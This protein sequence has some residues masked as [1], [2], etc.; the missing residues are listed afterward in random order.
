MYAHVNSSF[1]VRLNS[2]GHWH[3]IIR[4]PMWKLAFRRRIVGVGSSGARWLLDPLLLS[5][6][7]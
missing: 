2:V 7:H 6:G 1:T 5:V 3:I 4:L